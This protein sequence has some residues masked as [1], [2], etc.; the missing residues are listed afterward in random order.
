MGS[1]LINLND[2]RPFDVIL[3]RPKN[4][5]VSKGIAHFTKGEYSHAIL[6]ISKNVRVEST[7]NGI[8]YSTP[9][10]S[11]CVYMNGRFLVFEDIS[12]YNEFDIYRHP[13]I[14]NLND[15]EKYKLQQE[16]IKIM[17]IYISKEYPSVSAFEEF[18]K[19]NSIAHS[20]YKSVLPIIKAFENKD[21]TSCFC[22]ELVAEL[23]KYIGI[24]LFER[25]VKSDK[26]SPNDLAK[27]KLRKVEIFKTNF[28]E[29]S[30]YEEE[31]FFVSYIKTCRLSIDARDSN[32][33]LNINKT[34]KK[35]VDL[36]NMLKIR[37]KETRDDYESIRRIIANEKPILDLIY[38]D[39][40]IWRII[41]NYDRTKD[42]E[43]IVRKKE[44]IELQKKYL[45]LTMENLED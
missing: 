1:D 42:N 23:Y 39:N 9:D 4:S 8:I 44:Y 2:I 29:I 12:K 3:T 32:A 24:N 25:E 17:E 16:L 26:I 21:D 6:V 27:S 36:S 7:M 13:Y 34:F 18:F 33:N 15:D 19:D 30:N 45:N 14:E 10:L 35:M 40:E 41:S 43:R 37:E 11:K 20:L 38:L 5:I 28:N 31:P 22:S